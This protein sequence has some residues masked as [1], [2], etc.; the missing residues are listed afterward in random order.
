MSTTKNAL[1]QWRNLCAA[2]KNNDFGNMVQYAQRLNGIP[3]QAGTLRPSS[4]PSGWLVSFNKGPKILITSRE[5]KKMINRPYLLA[6]FVLD[7][8]RQVCPSKASLMK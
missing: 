7:Y 6:R 2:A 3:D 5:V 1:V 8:P 4:D